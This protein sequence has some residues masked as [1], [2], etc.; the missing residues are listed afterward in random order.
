MKHV[1]LEQS[2]HT[3][4]MLWNMLPIPISV[5]AYVG[6]MLPMQDIL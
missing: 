3:G 4:C 6:C 2:G 5:H 1:V